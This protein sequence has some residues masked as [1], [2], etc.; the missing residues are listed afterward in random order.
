MGADV[1]EIII[2]DTNYTQHLGAPAEQRMG[3]V[4]RNFSAYPVGYTAAARPFDLPLIPESEWQDRLNAKVSNQDFLS[5]IR[6][7]SNFGQPIPSRDQDGKGY[8]W[9]HSTVSAVL[10]VRAANNQPYADLSAY[11]IACIIKGYRDEGGWNQQSMDFL[12]ERGCP[13]SEFWPQQSMSR[14]NDRPTT[15]DNAKLYAGIE[16]MDLD[17]RDMKRQL[18]TCLLMDIPVAID[19]NWWSHSIC[20]CDLVN[21]NPFRI[22]IWN[23]WGDTWSEQGMG[24]LEGSKAIPD[25]ATALR[26]VRA[27]A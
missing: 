4:P 24:I 11:A 7:T 21:L 16:G 18:V 2:T 10:L 1:S 8:C 22:R 9:A 15:W 6:K 26:V 27:T 12:F 13:T 17:P 25:G 5:E 20:A 19:L 3:L 14:A 23:S